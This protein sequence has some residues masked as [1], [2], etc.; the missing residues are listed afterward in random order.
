MKHRLSIG[1]F[2]FCV[3][4]LLG[5][6]QLSQDSKVQ[7]ATVSAN[8]KALAEEF[9]GLAPLIEAKNEAD[10][11]SV[12]RFVVSHTEGLNAQAL[13]FA[14]AKAAI[15]SGSSL[16]KNMRAQLAEFTAT[17]AERAKNFGRVLPLINTRDSITIGFISKNTEG[18]NEKLQ[19]HRQNLADFSAQL[20]RLNLLVNPPAK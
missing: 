3:L 10:A 5:C 15:E 18:V 1:V 6:Q 17:A 4:A 7:L 14:D 20:A 11:P 12:K 13:G 19:T 8:A 2:A 16:G 9:N